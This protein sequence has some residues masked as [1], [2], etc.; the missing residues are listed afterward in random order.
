MGYRKG[1]RTTGRNDCQLGV[2]MTPYPAYKTTNLPWLPKI[3]EHWE[4]R[5][6]HRICRLQGG[7][8][9]PVRYQGCYTE[10]IPFIKVNSLASHISTARQYDTVSKKTADLLGAKVFSRGDIVFAK[11]GAAL[12]LHRFEMLPFDCCIDNNMMAMYHITENPKWLQ[13]TLSLL[14]FNTL[15]NPG[16]VPSINQSQ[17]AAMTIPCP[18]RNEQEQIVRYLDSMTAKINKLIRAKKKQIA[19]LQEQRQAIINQ[20]VTRGL[21]P[22]VET[23]RTNS[24]ICDFIPSNWTWTT[25]KRGAKLLGGFAF[26]SSSFTDSGTP[27]IRMSNL[28]RGNLDR[29]SIV[30]VKQYPSEFLLKKGDILWGM[31]GSIGKTGSLG[32][33]A[34][35]KECDLPALLNQR[36]GKFIVNEKLLLKDYLLFLI[37][38]DLFYDQIIL[39][40][41]GT[42]QFNISSFQVESVEIPLPPLKEQRDIVLSLKTNTKKYDQ[43]ISLY[44][45][46]IEA[47]GEYKNSL[48]SSVVTGQIDVRNIPAEDV[49]PDDLIAEDDPTSEIKEAPTNDESEE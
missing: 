22:D 28:K 11:V 42:A 15:V 14:N 27:V 36:V 44:Q 9:F 18:P 35:V 20:A 41:T 39:F 40:S 25:L 37:Q 2:I 23:R 46:Q 10:S 24:R 4:I 45:K 12:L 16:T 43:Y 21:D 38:S 17:V 49:I 29:S 7:S 19:L 48:I 1:G 34:I 32:N 33:Y 26:N 31:S 47:F 8:G 30:Y 3:P 13:Y 6:I 5:T